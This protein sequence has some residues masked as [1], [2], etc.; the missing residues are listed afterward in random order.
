MRVY[1]PPRAQLKA[2]RTHCLGVRARASTERFFAPSLLVLPISADG[3]ADVHNVFSQMAH[4]VQDI[5][6]TK[7]EGTTGVQDNAQL[8][9]G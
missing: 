3:D 9:G 5:F 6:P 1:S 4:I 7:P 8:P 2:R